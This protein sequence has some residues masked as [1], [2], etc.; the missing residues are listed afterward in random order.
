MGSPFC[1][2]NL[3]YFNIKICKATLPLRDE[4]CNCY[5]SSHGKMDS[6][7]DV[8]STLNQNN[9]QTPT[10]IGVEAWGTDKVLSSKDMVSEV[11]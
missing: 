10:I 5:D 11:L 3:A 7:R 4:P 2:G 1:K 8:S 9:P 6:H